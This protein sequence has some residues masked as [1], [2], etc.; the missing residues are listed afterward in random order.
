MATSK[1]IPRRLV[2]DTDEKMLQ[3]SDMV[4]ALNVTVSDDGE[5]TSGVIKNVRGTEKIY[6]DSTILE[7]NDGFPFYGSGTKV[8]G[9][10]EDDSRGHIYFFVSKDD[11]DTGYAADNEDAIYRYSKDDGYYVEV[12]KRDMGFGDEMNITATVVSGYFSQ[13]TSLET[14]VYF[15][16]DSLLHPPRKINADRAIAGDYDLRD[17]LTDGAENILLSTA[18]P[19]TQICP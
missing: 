17:D 19:S 7:R 5:G 10:V 12:L 8:I 6:F 16:G 11:S 9:T 3:P 18:K 14:I 2:S 1:N 13:T 15:T 4:D